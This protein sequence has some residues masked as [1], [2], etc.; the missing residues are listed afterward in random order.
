MKRMLLNRSYNEQTIDRAIDKATKIPRKHA[1]KKVF[2]PQNQT[3]PIFAVK[4]DPRIPSLQN[5]QNKHWRSMLKSD[6]YLSQVFPE[7]PLT[8]FK[9]Q[10]TLKNIL[11]KT[12]VPN[13][14]KRNSVREIKG[15]TKCTKSC[16][17]CPFMKTTKE[18][19]LNKNENWFINKR[20]NCETYNCIYLIE[21][22]KENC[23]A[24]YI[25]QTKRQFKYRLA[26][27]RGY[28]KNQVLSTPI[29]QH[30]NLPGHCLADLKSIILEQV[31]YNDEGY[32]LEREKYLIN[33]FNT[34]HQGLNK[35]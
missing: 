8:A 19:K 9:K 33:K 1:L 34:F 25:G 35:E 31:K 20:L 21:C 14:P 27:H 17:A 15:S 32:R 30:F 26:N 2:R 22:Q 6:S 5:I 13:Q 11:V 3:R 12:K 10:S 7:P 4:Y 29:G 24:K 23:K 18:V 16:T 28:V